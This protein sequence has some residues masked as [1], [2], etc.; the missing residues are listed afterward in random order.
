MKVTVIIERGNDGRYSAYMD[1]GSENLTFG[2][3]GEGNTV[4]ETMEDFLIGKD[5][6]KELYNDLNKE[7]PDLEFEF[8]YDMP[9]FLTYYS[10]VFTKSALERMTGINQA[11]LS[12]YVSGYRRPSKKTVEKLDHAIR[13][14]ANELSQVHF[15]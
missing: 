1:K 2:L 15:I 6:M 8:M 13:Q 4:K 12:Q 7:F 5:E 14:L 9:S 10:T 11:Q 3:L